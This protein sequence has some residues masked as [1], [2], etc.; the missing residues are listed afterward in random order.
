ME[1]T[2]WEVNAISK[3]HHVTS[4]EMNQEHYATSS[5]INQD[6]IEEVCVE[7]GSVA[8]CVDFPPV[9]SIAEEG[10]EV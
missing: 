6:E 8:L 7:D 3:E 4:S 1:D 10:G 9:I 5:A 2:F